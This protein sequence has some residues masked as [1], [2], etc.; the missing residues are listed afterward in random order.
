M[1]YMVSS[2][3]S[4]T[5]FHF[6]YISCAQVPVLKVGNVVFLRTKDVQIAINKVLSVAPSTLYIPINGS[7][8]TCT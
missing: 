5:P 4:R 3:L 1:P 7:S 6:S 2:P 8:S